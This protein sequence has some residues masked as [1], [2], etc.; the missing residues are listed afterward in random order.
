MNDMEMLKAQLAE[1]RT[2]ATH[3]KSEFERAESLIKDIGPKIKTN[4]DVLRDSFERLAKG[5]AMYGRHIDKCVGRDKCTC[6]FH[7][8][9]LFAQEMA[10]GET[11]K[12]TTE[13]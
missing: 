13:V 10:S 6:G 5:V 8:F 11:V 1:A 3:W 2:Q 7:E 12:D 4:V 9:F